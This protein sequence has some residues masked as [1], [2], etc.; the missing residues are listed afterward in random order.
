[1]I[2]T[3]NYVRVIAI[4]AACMWFV[5]WGIRRKYE[6]DYKLDKRAWIIR[7]SIIALGVICLCFRSASFKYERLFFGVAA[8]VFLLWPNFAYHLSVMSRRDTTRHNN[9][10]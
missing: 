3:I 9:L 8:D 2:D 1:M 6:L 10:F 5:A 7:I 4:N